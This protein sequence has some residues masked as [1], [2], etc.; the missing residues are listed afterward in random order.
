MCATVGED[1]AF[2]TYNITLYFK[3]V[4]THIFLRKWFEYVSSHNLE[5][6]K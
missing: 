4:I 1:S 6:V 5:N 3:N 2:C